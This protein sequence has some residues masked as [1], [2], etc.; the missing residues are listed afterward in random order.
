MLCV[1]S[2]VELVISP[3]GE[4]TN[5]CGKIFVLRINK[6]CARKL[7][8]LS[9]SLQLKLVLVGDICPWQVEK[10]KAVDSLGWAH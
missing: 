9:P 7:P 2:L 6:E 5:P 3:G 4:Q 10:D 1:K 8:P